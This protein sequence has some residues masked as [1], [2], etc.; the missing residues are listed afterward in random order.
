MKISK[1]TKAK[2]MLAI[3]TACA[4][5]AYAIPVFAGPGVRG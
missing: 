3:V 2:I 4:F 5:M 1:R